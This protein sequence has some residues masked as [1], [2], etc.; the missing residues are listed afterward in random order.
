M[1]FQVGSMSLNYETTSAALIL[2][3]R[4]IYSLVLPHTIIVY[5]HSVYSRRYV[6]TQ[7]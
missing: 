6:L 3:F 1:Q 2:E 4:T 5:D 7:M